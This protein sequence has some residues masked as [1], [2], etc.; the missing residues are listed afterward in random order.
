V[1]A[2][3]ELQDLSPLS[4]GSL[5]SAMTLCVGIGYLV[6]IPLATA[7]GRRPVIVGSAAVTVVATILAGV[8]NNFSQL[9]AA[10]AL[11]G[12]AIGGAISMVYLSSLS[13]NNIA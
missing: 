11:Q 3:D 2:N 1:I 4:L 13:C 8:S 5:P 12:F 10:L 7:I 6:C 9:L